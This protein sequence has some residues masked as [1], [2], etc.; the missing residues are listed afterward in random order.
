M[1]TDAVVVDVSQDWAKASEVQ[2]RFMHLGP[3]IETLSYSARCRQVRE[4]GGDFYDFLP[5]PDK[6]LAMAIGDASGKSVAGAL[7]IANVQA[8]LRTAAAFAGGNCALVVEAVNRQVQASSL[9]DRYATLFYGVFDAATRT[10]RYVNAGHYPPL[11]IGRDVPAALLEAGGAPVGVFADSAYEEGVVQLS[12]GDLVVAYTD[13]IVEAVNP[14]G[15]EWGIEGLRR[16]A[17]A[18]KREDADEVVRGI[19]A[20]VEEFSQGRQSDD[21]TVL[22]LRAR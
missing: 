17:G 7:M 8:S 21:A 9:T 19:F 22:V 20:A 15:R 5:L 1:E 16:A 13:G 14:A 4:L 11:V 2:Q 3:A 6:S 18:C 12:A 10:L